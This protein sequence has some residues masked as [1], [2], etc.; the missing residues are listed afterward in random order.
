MPGLTLKDT[1]SWSYSRCNIFQECKR[2]YYYNYYSYWGGWKSDADPATRKTYVLKNMTNLKIFPGDV[3]HR[4]IKQVLRGLSCGKAIELD[5][6]KERA[7]KMLNQGWKESRDGKW[8]AD[9]KRRV[10]LFEHYY[11]LVVSDKQTERIKENVM[12]CLD[13]FYA[14]EIFE[15]IKSSDPRSW[16]AFQDME[17]FNLE[18]IKV[19]AIPD[20]AFEH[21]EKTVLF[22][23]KSGIR[24][25]SH[26]MQ[27]RCY[28][29]LLERKWGRPLSKLDFNILYLR[30]GDVVKMEVTTEDVERMAKFIKSSFAD[31][32]KLLEDQSNNI[33][34]INTFP[35][36]DK[37]RRC[38][39]CSFKELCFC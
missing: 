10:N 34:R 21:N 13:N 23:W 28:A 20:F 18:D 14:S 6:A 19:F 33:A 31:M 3:I 27:M 12:Q 25:S 38:E 16:L 30:S 4:V 9:P 8:R 11:K 15:D 36:P 29:L 5:L 39:M 1:L 24:S 35:M 26:E 22:D 7:R 2:K 32:L 37:S 17:S